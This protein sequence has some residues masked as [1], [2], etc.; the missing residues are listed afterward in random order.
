MVRPRGS[1]P[2][3]TLQHLTVRARS[4]GKMFLQVWLLLVGFSPCIISKQNSTSKIHIPN[5]NIIKV[6]TMQKTTRN[7][8]TCPHRNYIT[9]NYICHG[10]NNSKFMM[11]SK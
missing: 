2:P 6:A 1:H 3:D 4:L 10:V 11:N 7:N 5:L 8:S 9:R